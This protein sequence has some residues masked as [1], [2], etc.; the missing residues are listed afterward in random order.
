MPNK[1]RHPFYDAGDAGGRY[2]L[3][4]L[5]AV[6]SVLSPY[7][8]KAQKPTE[9][10]VPKIVV[11]I[12]VDQ[13]RSDYLEA[14]M[15]LYGEG[16]FKRLFAEGRVYTQTDY[17]MARPDRASAAATLSTGVAPSSHG[18]VGRKWLDRKTL[19]PV[20]CVETAE[21]QATGGSNQM[22]TS[23]LRLGVSTIGDE[24][25]VAAEGKALVYAIAP[26]RETAVLTAGHAADGVVWIDDVTGQ[27]CSSSYYGGL[28]SWAG[29]CNNYY[30]LDNRLRTLSWTPSSELVGNFSYFLS[31]GMKKPFSHKFKGDS[32]FADFKTSGLVNEEVGHAVKTLLE[33]T[34]VGN[35]AI[36]DHLALTFY[37]GDYAKRTSTG[38]SMELQD[39]Y[40]RLDK[41]LAEVI[42]A[43]QQ[44][45]GEDGALFV[46][47][48]TGYTDENSVDL[49]RFR[50]PTGTFDMRRAVSLLNMYLAAIYG[51][52]V[53]VEAAFG[54]QL[55][56]DHKLIE[57]RQLNLA[58]ILERTQDFL[59]R[60]AGVKDVYTSQRLLL[61]AWTPGLSRIRGGYNPQ[62]S[63]DIM[64]EILPGWHLVNNDT[65]ENR[66]IREAYISY[67][68]L[69]YG[70]GVKAETLEL[71]VTVDRIAPTLSKAMRIRAPNACAAAPL[72]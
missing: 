67:P 40:V 34:M 39:T 60:L 68:I 47:T 4:S 36:P 42:T 66:L 45:V 15:P 16:G 62:C 13:L 31:G 9:N 56:F 43:I 17:P 10:G 69:F 65:N 25:K 23:A 24:L 11:S 27:W 20:F 7:E 48:S 58:E 3:L 21:P 59:I 32:R 72:F 46:L 2:L 53:Y 54:D 50:I 8:A 55:Y 41:A 61:G 33:S 5:L 28:P 51:Q 26:F 57:D 44:K 63:G 52:G 18:I 71:P 29:V 19:R 22:L 12:L 14:F 70:N 38:T 35:D 64:L 37:A 6:M 49:S 1:K 30:N